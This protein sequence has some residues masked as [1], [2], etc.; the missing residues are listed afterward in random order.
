[1]VNVISLDNKKTE[2]VTL[3]EVF[4]Q[5]LN[6][7]LLKRA[8]LAEESERFQLKYTDPLAGMRKSAELTKRRRAY[9]TVYGGRT[10]TPKKTLQH[11]GSHFSYVGAVAPNTVGGREAHPPKAEKVLVKKI[12]KKERQLAIRMGIAGSAKR[13][14]VSRFHKVEGISELPIILDDKVNHIKK[15][16]ETLNA[17][18]SAGLSKELDR[19][20]ERS[21]R[22]GKGKLRGRK[23]KKKL[24]IVLV[25][26]DDSKLRKA[27]AN[28]NIRVKKVGELSVSD[29]T[30]AGKPGRLVVWTKGAIESL[31]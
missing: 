27:A 4:N 14:L 3:P 26:T 18:S 24:G 28:L 29:V 22:A 31:K 21:I 6:T 10:R 8:Y 17:L 9:K 11:V 13:E 2:E 23:Y 19:I 16:K 30:Q 5:E 25:T 12:N 20:M 7:D 1:M 15:T